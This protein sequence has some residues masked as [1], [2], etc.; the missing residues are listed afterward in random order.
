ML[1][2][3]LSPP[4]LF[5]L[6]FLFRSDDPGSPG[7]DQKCQKGQVQWLR[8]QRGG[9]EGS[10]PGSKVKSPVVSLCLRSILFADIEGF[11]SLASQC[12]AQELV[13]TLNELFARFDKLAAVRT[14]DQRASWA[15]RLGFL[16][17]RP[18]HG[19]SRGTSSSILL[20]SYHSV[21]NGT[22]VVCSLLRH[23]R[24]ERAAAT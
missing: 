8:A 12:T 10:R 9:E 6:T 20:E 19:G 11:T 18:P 22:A 3:C 21:F 24:D 2:R 1:P 4:R 15:E 7:S 16:I 5:L 23:V 13:M 17:T 14:I